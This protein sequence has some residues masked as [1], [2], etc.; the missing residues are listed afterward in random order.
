[1]PKVQTTLKYMEVADHIRARIVTG[2]FRPGDM[3]PAQRE[4]ADELGVSRD[5]VR[6]AMD[7]LEASGILRCVPCVGSIVEQSPAQ[8]AIVGYL[9]SNLSDPF[10]SEIIRELDQA[11]TARNAALL[12]AE[13][14]DPRRVLDAGA[15]RL[16]K[17]HYEG[18][19]HPNDL[20]ATV[21]VG[22]GADSK[23]A[24][25]SADRQGIRLLFDHLRSLGHERIAYFGPR[26]PAGMDERFD[27]FISAR[28]EVGNAAEKEVFISDGGEASRARMLASIESDMAPPTALMCFDDQWAIAVLRQAQQMGLRVPQDLSITGYDDI[29]MSCLLEVPLTTISFAAREIARAA[30]EI[31]FDED[32]SRPKRRV[33]PVELKA[34]NSTGPV[35]VPV[36]A[37][38]TKARKKRNRKA[39][40]SK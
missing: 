36:K 1:M 33:I 31:L 19:E 29:P 10:H 35:P 20:P 18:C 27:E 16:I 32:V 24:V 7:V 21:Y 26:L 11:L 2:A 38:G 15:T 37:L 40:I 14:E 9:V 17:Q 30:I 13:G 25:I 22:G 28:R 39:R 6:R 34:R 23:H 4:I 3:I 12:V 8:T 5:S